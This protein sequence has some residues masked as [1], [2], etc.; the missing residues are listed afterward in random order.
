[1]DLDPENVDA[2]YF[3]GQQLLQQGDSSGA[4]SQWRKVI[5]IQPNNMQALYSLS[6]LLIKT[7]PAEA[8]RLQSEAQN[9]VSEGRS[10]D[11]AE[12]LGN[13]ALAAASAHDW[14]SAVA[15]L[16]EALQVCGNCSAL[17]LLHKDL[18]LI[19]C[20]SGDLKDGQ[21]ELLAAQKLTPQDPEVAKALKIIQTSKH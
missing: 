20:R 17:A 15:Q 5:A 12:L 13:Q 16:R 11:R 3:L 18:G 10:T 4:I 6:R 9:L 21:I 8:R 7:D 19:Y 1:M 14:S 2:R